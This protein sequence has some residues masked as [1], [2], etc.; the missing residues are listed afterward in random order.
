[1]KAYITGTD[2]GLGLALVETFL[3]YGYTVYAG[4]FGIDRSGLERLQAQYGDQLEIVPLDVSSDKSVREAAEIIAGKTSSLDLLINNAAI[5]GQKDATVD[6]P[7]DFNDMLNVYN[8]NALGPLRVAQSVLPLLRAG[9]M[10]RII[11]ISSEA[12]SMAARVRRGQCTRYAYCGSKAALN[13]QSILLQNHVAADGIR[14]TLVEPGWLRTFLA[15]KEKCTI[16]PCEPEESAER[17]AAFVA[18]PAPDYLFHDLF[19]DKPFD[20]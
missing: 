5:I 10:K 13:I 2:R 18:R 15:S 11:N 17:L 20:W 14:L 6:D 9:E 12:G 4:Y 16:A 1:M 19:A 3:K 7:L 8:V